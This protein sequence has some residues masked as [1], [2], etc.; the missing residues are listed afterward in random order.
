MRAVESTDEAVL[1]T[2]R[3]RRI[4]FA[5]QAFLH[6]FGLIEDLGKPVIGAINGYL[7]TRQRMPSLMTTLGM[8]FALRGLVYVYTKKTPIV[9]EHGFDAFVQLYQG[10]IGPIPV[11]GLLIRQAQPGAHLPPAFRARKP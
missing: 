8:M 7:V 5:N 3:R 6:L 11:P 2:D 1:I 9:D 4:V 10:S